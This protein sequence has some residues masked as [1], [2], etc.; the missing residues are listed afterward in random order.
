MGAKAGS[1]AAAGREG[2]R[3]RDGRAP[4]DRDVAE[5]AA[6]EELRERRRGDGPDVREIHPKPPHRVDRL[7]VDGLEEDPAARRQLPRHELHEVEEARGRKV[8]DHLKR[9]HAAERGVLSPREPLEEVG[10]VDVQPLFLRARRHDR[11]RVAAD[12]AEPGR[13]Q[14]FEELAAPAPEVGDRPGSAAE[15]GY[16]LLLAGPDLLLRAS[17]DVFEAGVEPGAKRIVR[18]RDRGRRSRGRRRRAGRSQVAP[19]GR[20]FQPEL[21]ECALRLGDPLPGRGRELRVR[22]ERVEPLRARDDLRAERAP[23]GRFSRELLLDGLEAGAERRLGATHRLVEAPRRP[24]GLGHRGGGVPKSRLGGVERSAKRLEDRR[25]EDGLVSRHD[26]ED[27]QKERLRPPHPGVARE[28]WRDEPRAVLEDPAR[29]GKVGRGTG[30]PGRGGGRSSPLEPGGRRR[31]EGRQPVD[32]VAR[33]R[34]DLLSPLLAW[35]F[36]VHSLVILRSPP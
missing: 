17:K 32:E 9:R 26:P 21:P 35:R 16:I 34:R 5:A 28:M 25:V 31:R 15:T 13:L 7:R 19:H 29:P 11:V 33:Q 6:G 18:R 1:F 23:G 14:G 27:P 2:L 8:L 36:R 30:G 10:P 22:L 3:R 12:A 20:P 4:V 24:V